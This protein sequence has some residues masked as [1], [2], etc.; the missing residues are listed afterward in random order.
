MEKEIKVDEEPAPKPKKLAGAVSL[1]GGIDPFAAKKNLRSSSKEQVS[2]KFMSC[3]L[4][5]L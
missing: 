5:A 1:F 4:R 2:R 3:L